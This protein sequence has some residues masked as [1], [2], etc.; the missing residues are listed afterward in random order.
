MRK[1]LIFI[2]VLACLT[3]GMIGLYYLLRQAPEP[4]EITD[5]AKGTAI[6][7][8]GA[9]ARIPQEAALLEQMYNTGELKDIAF[10]SGVRSGALNAVM[11]HIKPWAD[12]TYRLCNRKISIWHHVNGP[13]R[14]NPS[15]WI[16]F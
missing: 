9:A 14:I 2:G 1:F 10:I 3:G 16:C 12:Q 4:E 8:T 13:A 15:H 6:V 7:I 5:H 11:P